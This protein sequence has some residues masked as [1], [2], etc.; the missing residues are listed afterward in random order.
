M[1]YVILASNS[2]R[3]VVAIGTTTGKVFTSKEAAERMARKL[4]NLHPVIDYLVLPIE[5][6]VL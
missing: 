4:T 6:A 3:Q 2:S 5:G 1:S